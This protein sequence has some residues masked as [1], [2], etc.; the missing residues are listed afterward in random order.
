MSD[1]DIR[2]QEGA[3]TAEPSNSAFFDQVQLEST[4]P[5]ASEELPAESAVAPET[6]PEAGP[7]PGEKIGDT[8][9]R[10]TTAADVPPLQPADGKAPR[11][12]PPRRSPQ[13]RTRS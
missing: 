1:N 4:G 8:M 10:P 7:E 12:T 3:A 9:A 2:E 5:I 13:G 11:T 6:A